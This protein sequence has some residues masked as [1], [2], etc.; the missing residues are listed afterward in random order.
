MAPTIIVGDDES[1]GDVAG[2]L[3][4][5]ADHQR[6]VQVRTDLPSPAFEVP[7]A[8]YEKYTGRTRRPE[9]ERRVNAV[10]RMVADA[11]TPD[12]VTSD[13]ELPDAARMADPADVDP[14]AAG[15]VTSDDD[16]PREAVN[17][18]PPA[19]GEYPNA[20]DQGAAADA[21]ETGTEPTKPTKRAAT[22]RAP[23]KAAAKSA[24]APAGGG[25]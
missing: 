4:R 11:D 6:D 24:P 21:D 1:A 9:A 17:V 25:E 5:L 16:L 10:D 22:K 15:A 19:N 3:L 14:D 18:D 2:K 20:G 8:V 7:D 12:A 13:D 23:R